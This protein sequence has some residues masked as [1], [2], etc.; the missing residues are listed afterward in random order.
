MATPPP[1]FSFQIRLSGVQCNRGFCSHQSLCLIVKPFPDRSRMADAAASQVSPVSL[2]TALLNTS[3][4][5]HLL[6]SSP[7]LLLSLS[8][9]S[10]IP[11]LQLV[12]SFSL[13]SPP[14]LPPCCCLSVLFTLFCSAPPSPWGLSPPS[15]SLL[16]TPGECQAWRRLFGS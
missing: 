13:H 16:C 11:L 5:P 3:A 7:I 8:F 10:A 9:L 6:N 4:S 14:L 12:S 2:S 1:R 15:P